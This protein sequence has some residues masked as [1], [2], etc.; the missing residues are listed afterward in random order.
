M[1][2]EELFKT[3]IDSIVSQDMKTAEETAKRAVDENI[4]LLELMNKGFREGITKIGELFERGEIFLPELIQSAEVMKSVNEI[5]ISALPDG[6]QEKNGVVVVGTVQGDIHDIGKILVCSLLKVNGFDVHDIGHDVKT[7][8]FI[9]KAVEVDADII[10][11]SSLLTTTM[12][13]QKELEE[14]LQKRGLRKKFKTMVGGAPVTQR[15][16]ERI[17]A[18]AYGEDATDAVK[19]ALALIGR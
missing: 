14:T 13:Y 8:S 3:A 18:D 7:E 19:K 1:E 12:R 5:I 6:A 9:D 16:A 11:T 17:G 4:D 15:W 10:G 2:K